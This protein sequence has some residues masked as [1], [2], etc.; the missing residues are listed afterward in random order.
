[1]SYVG[2]DFETYSPI[3]LKTDGLDN[4]VNDPD[5]KVL[6]AGI[7]APVGLQ[8]LIDFVK[9]GELTALGRLRTAIE[10]RQIV[11]HNAGFERAVLRRIGIDLPANRFI[12]T[13]VLARAAGAGGSLAAAS[14]QLL[15]RNKMEEGL[16]L[17]KLFCI[18]P[19]DGSPVFDV[20]LPDRYPDEWHQFGVY[21]MLDAQLSMRLKELLYVSPLMQG[22]IEKSWLTMDMND[23]GWFVDLPATKTMWEIYQDNLA[24]VL[25]NFRTIVPSAA[26]LNLSST[27]QL[28]A[29]CKERGVR[30]TSFDEKHVA[31]MVKRIS[32]KLDTTTDPDKHEGLLEVYQMLRVKQQLGGSAL[33]KLPTIL[34][35]T[36][37]RDGRLRDQYLHV[38]ADATFRTTGRG[39]QMQNLKRLPPNPIDMDNLDRYHTWPNQTLAENMRQLFMAQYRFGQLIVGDFSSIE[40]RALAWQA[41]EEWKLD[42]YHRGEDL[43]KVQ[44]A[45]MFGLTNTVDVSKEQRQVGK[46][47][48]LSC[49]YGAGPE[50]VRSFAEKMGVDLTEADSLSLVRDWRAANPEIVQYWA[51]L[52]A[53]LHHCMH[54]ATSHTASVVNIG[55]TGGGTVSVRAVRAPESLIKQ[56]GNDDLKSLRV[57]VTIRDM[58][59]RRVIHGAYLHGRNICY[60]K[61]ADRKTGDLWSNMFT[62]PK[63]KQRRRY[64]VYGGKLAGLLTQSLA[65]EMFFVSLATVARAISGF[66]NV[67]LV[68]QFHDEIV[69]EW[70]PDATGASLAAAVALLEQ[71]MR[72]TQL[73]AF[74][75]EAVVKHDHRYTK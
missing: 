55:P 70:T 11:A 8:T 71:S 2:L 35:T 30:A 29:W 13:A 64:S 25:L 48:E 6:L 10:G 28:I 54:P 20:T 60:W 50:A 33:K 15:G 18:P 42:A 67:K 24:V 57:Q 56:T 23:V 69:L 32:K 27:P 52:D 63:T 36:S 43:Y 37:T 7:T 1:M 14:A 22:E 26:E 5:F 61:P 38:G 59:F 44:A 34:S 65:R 9:E 74:P 16:D 3:N 46:V 4:Y 17:I 19:A 39:V 58:Q 68:G 45:T 49:G 31:S 51:N 73:P 41:H 53:A 62:D 40:S 47:G 21:C 66:S 75:L 12:D 72:Y